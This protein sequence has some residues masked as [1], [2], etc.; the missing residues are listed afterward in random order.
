[1]LL[2]HFLRFWLHYG[3]RIW[4]RKLY[5]HYEAPW[6][7]DAPLLFAC[8]HPNSAVDFIFLPLI[9]GRKS[10]V[11]VRGDVFEN[12]W[13]NRM[14]RAIWMLPV[15]RMRDGFKTISKN[16]GSF[17]EC[18]NEFDNNGRALIFSEGT[19]VQEKLLQPLMKGT[20]RLAIDYIMSGENKEIYVVPMANNYT[21]FRQF[22]GTVMTNFGKPIRVSDYVE[23]DNENQA[24]GYQKL[25]SEIHRALSTILIQQKNYRDDSLTEKALK[26]LRF[27]RLDERQEWIIE[28]QSVFIQ[29]QKV[30]EWMNEHDGKSLPKDFEERFNALE[31]DEHLEGVL[32]RS[33]KKA[34]HLAAMISTAFVMAVASIVHFLPYQL[35]RWIARNK[36]KDP[37]FENTIM[38]LGST[39]FYVLQFFIVLTILTSWIG[40]AGFVTSMSMLAVTAVY[41]E[42]VD[43]YRFAKFNVQKLK[44]WN[45]YKELYDDLMKS[46]D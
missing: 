29:E 2:F 16:K 11:M 45:A 13:L 22:R 27:N 35:S 36:I 41:S 37:L 43:D 34:F 40:W 44:N 25:T 7:K 30:T 18:F 15:Y 42:I 32:K 12:R 14:F 17:I 31:V 28:D 9:T 26:V 10:F 1:M 39:V 20:A 24:K 33:R 46:I 6:P 4:F 21:R 8:T 5:V 19:S 3:M 23:R 38:T